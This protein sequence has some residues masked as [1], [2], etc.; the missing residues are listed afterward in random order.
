MAPAAMT[1]VIIFFM[2]VSSSCYR[3]GLE[4][5]GCRAAQAVS[6]SLRLL[7][8]ACFFF[9]LAFAPEA[10]AVGTARSGSSGGTTR[11]LRC[12]LQQPSSLM[13]RTGPEYCKL[14]RYITVLVIGLPDSCLPCYLATGSYL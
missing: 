7:L 2:V 13:L 6:H 1:A 3:W 10:A 14:G 8:H 12:P 11:L 4:P 5:A 9:V